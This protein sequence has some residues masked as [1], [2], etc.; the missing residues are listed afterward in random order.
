MGETG[1]PATGESGDRARLRASVAWSALA[2]TA[3]W[4]LLAGEPGWAVP[5]VASGALLAFAIPHRDTGGWTG[6]LTATSLRIGDAAIAAALAWA[7]AGAG[8]LSGVAAASAALALALL[9]PYVR[10][11]ARSLEM[12]EAELVPGG[13]IERGLWLLLVASAVWSSVFSLGVAATMLWGAAGFSG[14]YVVVRFARIWVGAS[15][16]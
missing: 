15:R 1:A 2:A 12:P 5:P 9:A 10:T 14:A 16:G 6:F 11:R 3:A 13:S 4:L 8:T 7:F